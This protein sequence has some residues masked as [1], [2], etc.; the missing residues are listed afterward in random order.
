MAPEGLELG[1]HGPGSADLI[2]V[3]L[4]QALA[5]G[6]GLV[7]QAGCFEHGDVLLHSGERHV[8]VARQGA[9]RRLLGQGSTE[10]V[11]TRGVS[12][13]S[14]EAVELG[15]GEVSMYNHM[16]VYNDGVD[17]AG[18]IGIPQ[19]SGLIMKRLCRTEEVFV[20]APG[21]A[22]R[23]EVEDGIGVMTNLPRV[24]HSVVDHPRPTLHHPDGRTEVVALPDP[25]VSVGSSDLVRR[26]VLREIGVALLPDL[27][28]REQLQSGKL[29]RIAAPWIRRRLDVYA[30]TP[31][32]VTSPAVK[33]FLTALNDSIG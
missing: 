21:L 7:D 27:L 32:R 19:D 26:L 25:V 11:P 23:V 22:E 29:V 4:D 5:A 33:V 28:V 17:V 6:G 9:D 31:S 3:G 15:V 2:G 18:R 30:L 24:A 20:A 8:V 14:E 1:Q 16:V 12:Q 10:D 13:R